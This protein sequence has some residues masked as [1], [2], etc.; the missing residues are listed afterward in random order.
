MRDDLRDHITFPDSEQRTHREKWMLMD[1]TIDVR[2]DDD[3]GDG[4]S[5]QYQL[6]STPLHRAVSAYQGH[7]SLL[8]EL[9][10]TTRPSVGTLNAPDQHGYT[11]LHMAAAMGNIAVARALIRS[12]AR[13]NV[14]NWEGK[15]AI[16]IA[17][18]RHPK[19]KKLA[20]L[21]SRSAKARKRV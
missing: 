8:T 21:L 3:D 2:P 13:P 7:P 1:G 6:G 19:D 20:K 17:K 12:G 4:L 11:A 16:D 14:T 18:E 10:A 15:L 5:A 9:L